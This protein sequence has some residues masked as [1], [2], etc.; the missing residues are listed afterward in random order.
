MPRAFETVIG[1]EVH[2]QLH[3]KTKLF[4]SCS[5]AYGAAPNTQ[6]CPVCLGLPGALPVPSLA[7]ITMA[8]QAGL[9]LGCTVKPTS[10]FARKNYF[11]PD[12]PKGY[13]ISQFELPLNEKGFLDIQYNDREGKAV[14]KRVGIQRIHV[15]ED[16]A[17]NVHDAQ[18]AGV[19]IIDYNRG[20]TPLIEIVSEPD[21]R[22]AEEAEAY[23]RKLR[24]T[25]MF[26]GV[27]D[28]NLE[29]GS[30]RC[31]ANVSIRPVGETTLGTRTELKNIN[32]FKFVK[33]AI[34]FEAQRQA[35]V[36]QNG[37]TIVQET[38]T[39]SEERGETLTMRT[40]ED[41]HDYR[42][43]PDPDLPWVELDAAW[44]E[45]CQRTLAET[46]SQK[47]ERWTGTSGLTDYDAQLMSSHPAIA[48]FFDQALDEL[49]Q[50]LPR[51]KFDDATTGKRTANFIQAEV[52]RG[53]STDGLEGSFPVTSH[54]L[55]ELL[56][57]V[58]T[59]TINGKIAKDVYSD[60]VKSGESA[61]NIVDKK[62]LAQVTDTQEIERIA[63]EVL[64]KN[65]GEIEKY[66]AGKSNVFGFFVGQVMRAMGGRSNPAVVNEVVKKLLG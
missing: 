48:Q 2:A 40:K 27:N 66:R 5:T 17:K 9:G 51:G 64:A 6:I 44:I 18:A 20:G 43:F 52:L 59:E 36:I 4:C 53:T 57:M 49:K 31:D 14:S 24:E 19:T 55:A 12:L 29:E 33:K 25:L 50:Q 65:P 45:S 62:G 41:A 46:A 54:Q 37:G 47:R 28:G 8:I 1:L 30:F 26:L 63:K 13:Q 11:Y 60:M 15:E 10:I 32:S 22:S 39:W 38:R 35:M 56:A 3:T 16:A 23:L 21:M 58:L 42:Y 61:K 7:A 34:E